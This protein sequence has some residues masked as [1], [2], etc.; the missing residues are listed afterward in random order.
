MAETRTVWRGKA[1][2]KR[3]LQRTSWPV[4]GSE[5]AFHRFYVRKG[6]DD[7]VCEYCLSSCLLEV[8]HVP[9]LSRYAR[10]SEDERSMYEPVLVNACRRCNRL[11]AARPYDTVSAR[12]VFVFDRLAAR[13]MPL[14]FA[15]VDALIEAR[16]AVARLR[17][18]SRS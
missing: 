4:R 18:S 3:A 10:M 7:G 1:W 8:D 11:L 15:S 16:R 13:G 17:R 12:R 14:P 2:H 6:M 5:V 9:A